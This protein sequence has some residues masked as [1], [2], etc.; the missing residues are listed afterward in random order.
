MKAQVVARD[1]R[2]SGLRM[3]LNFG[4]TVGHALEQATGYKLLLHGE[5]V[6]WGMIA[7]LAVAGQ[8]GTITGPQQER[9]EALIHLYGPLP[10]VKLRVARVVAATSSDK[11]NVGG[12]RRFV[13]PVG[14]GDAG[15]LENVSEDE[16]ESAVGYML[17]RA[18]EQ[19]A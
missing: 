10:A 1:E 16:L 17:G 15:V 4:H 19:R 6:G 8:R 5:G 3:I 2:E 12:V 9:L 13:V 14:V 18:A 11:K 7:A